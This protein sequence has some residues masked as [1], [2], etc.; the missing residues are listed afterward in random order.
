MDSIE[1][2]A[3][4]LMT[5]WGITSRKIQQEFAEQTTFPLTTPQLF[6]LHL[7]SKK[8]RWM[9]TEL[10][11]KMS[12]KP[13]AIT[14]MIDRLEHNQFAERE[15][16]EKDRRVVFIKLSQKG[17]KVLKK[18]GGKRKNILM[19]YLNQLEEEEII[20]LVNINEKLAQIIG[21]TEK[22]K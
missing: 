8:D 20:S 4:R 3:E 6:L 10:A 15:R 13:S 11:D 17:K 19:D 22:K 7:L 9:V 14:A 21:E 12:V 16:D 1:T 5:A 2:L 18:A